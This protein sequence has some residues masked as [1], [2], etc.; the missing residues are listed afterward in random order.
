MKSKVKELSK[1][2]LLF[3]IGSVIYA[4]SVNCF[5]SPNNIAPGGLTG[6]GI[7]LNYLFEFPIGT[8]TLVMN[9][10]LFI[11]A[12][13]S[14]GKQFLGKSAVATVMVSV[15]I[16]AVKLLPIPSYT[17][18]RLLAAIFGG[19]FAGAGLAL[20]FLRGGTTGGTD[21]LARLFAKRF[22]AVPMGRMIL[23]FDAAVV[24]SSIFVFG[25]IESAL[26][27]FITIYV[28]SNVI[29][30]VLYGKD[31]G[32][33]L[34]I[35]TKNPEAVSKSIIE[36]LGRGVTVMQGKGAYT[37]EDSHVLM[38]AVRR[39]EVFRVRDIMV[40]IDPSSFIIVG[41]AAQ[42]LGQG[43]SNINE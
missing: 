2:Y 40:Q 10:P 43:F 11:W 37:G 3:F 32:K 41:D 23:F 31:T 42:V 26:Y 6:V 27:A 9:I 33:V 20:I 14:L 17:G 36:K 21:L 29:D 28:S 34:F 19:V 4:L 5:T 12:Y 18:D 7:M 15:I 22:R 13:I 8:A 1:D 35:V 16:D 25:N 24:T 38:C 39:N 30:S